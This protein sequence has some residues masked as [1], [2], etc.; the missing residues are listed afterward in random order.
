MNTRVAGSGSGS[1]FVT[2]ASSGFG[3]HVSA[4]MAARGRQ[5]VAS[6]RD[7]S[8]S[9]Y[10]YD[11]MGRYGAEPS[12]LSIIEL[13][14]T[15]PESR[16]GAVEYLNGMARPL[17]TVLHCA[18]YT[19]AAFFEDL[20]SESIRDQFETNF[21]GAVELTKLLLPGLRSRR[22]GTIAVISSNA[23]NIAHPMY[24]IYAASKWSLEGWAEALSIELA[25]FGVDVLI[26]QPGNHDTAFAS[27]V[28]SISPE[29]SPYAGLHAA[30]MGKLQALGDRAR[31]TVK[32]ATEICDALEAE[33][34]PLRLRIG[35]DDKLMA[36]LARWAP[37]GVRRRIVERI[38]GLSRSALAAEGPGNVTLTT[39]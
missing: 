31:P 29:A 14:V 6:M 4:M 5:V 8:K 2:G 18:G 3:A 26:L 16:E 13:D 7:A 35:N 38:T 37:Y 10:L 1:L 20:P 19:T 23:V 15:S 27:N 9:D 25:P 11:L 34:R 30:A 17:E 21:F 32:A 33:S 36:A 39:K 22:G 24:S 12:R 28:V